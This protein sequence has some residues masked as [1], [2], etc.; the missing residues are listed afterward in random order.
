MKSKQPIQFLQVVV[1]FFLIGAYDLPL[2]AGTLPSQKTA[3]TEPSTHWAFQPI[4]SVAPPRVDG[5]PSTNPIDAFILARLQQLGISPAPFASPK[6]LL[7]RVTYDLTGLPPTSAERE[8]FLRDTTSPGWE[9]LVD[10]LLSRPD[11]GERWAQHWLDLAH[12]ADSNGFELDADRP[13]AWRY[14]DW[15]VHSINQDLP[16]D[17]FLTL[18]IAGDEAAPGDPEALIASGFGRAGPREVVAGNIDPEVRRQNEL[19]EVVSSVGSVFLG[20]TVGCARCH[21][22]KFDPIPAADYYGLE[23]YFA[24][25]QL[26]ETAIHA[27][28]EKKSRGNSFNKYLTMLVLPAP[29]GAQTMMALRVIRCSSAAL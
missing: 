4:R 25:A 28:T 19:T 8:E 11:F 17:R 12:Y 14:R 27:E 6:D 7:R 20:L 18:Q 13:D 23:A 22:H 21:D 15:V 26:T 9:R 3:A 2:G 5:F 1:G 29:E 10:R 16:Y 24:G